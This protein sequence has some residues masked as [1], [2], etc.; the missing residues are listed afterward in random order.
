[1]KRLFSTW[2]LVIFSVMFLFAFSVMI[3][4]S[5]GMT[6]SQILHKTV[7]PL[8]DCVMP[9]DCAVSGF[10][11]TVI[12]SNQFRPK[13][14]GLDVFASYDFMSTKN[15]ITKSTPDSIPIL[16]EASITNFLIDDNGLYAQHTGSP[17]AF[18]FR[19]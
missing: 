5:H 2:I 16:N 8:N 9:V 10:D 6:E 12:T 13:G 14:E 15:K 7:I 4:E 18:V 3:T 11:R 1:M 19:E 17:P